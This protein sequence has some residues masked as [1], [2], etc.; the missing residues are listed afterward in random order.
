MLNR[1][2]NAKFIS[3]DFKSFNFLHLHF[4]VKNAFLFLHVFLKTFFEHLNLIF[5][6]QWE[7]KVILSLIKLIGACYFN[8]TCLAYSW[9]VFMKIFKCYSFVLFNFLDLIFFCFSL[10]TFFLFIC[11]FNFH[12]VFLF[13]CFII[14]V[15]NI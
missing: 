1:H 5:I 2:K 10:I 14:W 6:A 13:F 15:I 3:L 11:V 4:F 12:F 9:W 7:L 8:L